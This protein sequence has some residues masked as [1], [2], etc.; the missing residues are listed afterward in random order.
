[1]VAVD[2]RHAVAGNPVQG[3]EVTTHHHLAVRLARQCVNRRVETGADVELRVKH[4][5]AEQPR[6][7][8][9]R[10]VVN[11]REVAA[12]EDAAI[13]LHHQRA[14]RA[15]RHRRDVERRI[16]TTVHSLQPRQVRAAEPAH[17]RE[18]AAD[19]DVRIGIHRHGVNLRASVEGRHEGTVQHARRRESRD[20][21]ARHAVH[22]REETADDH[23]CVHVQR[24]GVNDVVRARAG[25]EA[26]IQSAGR[27]QARDAV[28]RRAIH[29]GERAGDDRLAIGL[30]RDREHRAIRPE[31]RAAVGRVQRTIRVQPR[32]EIARG[33]AHHREGAAD[34]YASIRLHRRGGNDVVRPRASV[35]GQVK[36]AICVEPRQPGEARAVEAQEVTTHEDLALQQRQRGIRVERHGEDTVG[37]A[38]TGIEERVRAADA[39]IV[40][41]AHRDVA[42]RAERGVDADGVVERDR[43]RPRDLFDDVVHQRH[44]N[45]EVGHARPKGE[46]AI[47]RRI[48]RRSGG[49]A[50]SRDEVHRVR[51]DRVSL[52][53]HRD[54]RVGAILQHAVGGGGE[55]ENDQIVRDRQHGGGPRAQ[56]HA[57]DV[58]EDQVHR[59]VALRDEV[60]DDRHIEGAREHAGGEVQRAV[61]GRVIKAGRRSAVAGEEVHGER[62]G[63]N[64]VAADGDERIGLVLQHGVA[65]QQKF[66]VGV[67]VDN[68]QGGRGGRAEHRTA[69]G[70]AQRQIHRLVRLHECVVDNRDAEILV[71]LAGVEGKRAH[72]RL[73]IKPGHGERA[74]ARAV[75]DGDDRVR[76]PRAGD[77]DDRSAAAF[78]KAVSGLAELHARVVVQNA[79]HHI[80][81]RAEEGDA[82]QVAQRDVKGLG[83]LDELLV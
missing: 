46:R 20:L 79:D 80:S 16:E 18:A 33:A 42:D 63:R 66:N 31:E 28:A 8:V 50:V 58:G 10:G 52:A 34:D 73:V 61:R 77:A 27:V 83:A 40:H 71:G 36:R 65:G 78:V 32:E 76:G 56:R 81:D 24:D 23:V 26:R 38:G 22:L 6:Q 82:G 39:V 74:V 62:V 12:H 19:E 68:R 4:A 30:N 17:L 48:I 21:R 41:D 1:M 13:N 35:E 29:H 3:R 60:L 59:A 44:G 64:A 57:D 5:V 67:V 9:T 49:G 37:R 15:V 43:E 25:V 72:L 53:D 70:Q 11:Q 45:G 47:G 14:H 55:L 51:P 2:P 75:I 69:R 54:E 7:A